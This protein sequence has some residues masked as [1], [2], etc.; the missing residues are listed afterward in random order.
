MKIKSALLLAL[1]A[2]LALGGIHSA[3]ARTWTDAKTGRTLSGDL[4][5]VKEGKVSVKRANG[6]LIQ[7]E[8]EALSKEDQDFVAKQGNAGGGGEGGWPSFRG[9]SRSDRSPDQGLLKK[10]PENGPKLLWQSE[11]CGKGYSG[12]A[13]VDGK[14][15]YT[16]T[17]DGKA[18]IICLNSED[19]KEVWSSD[20]GDDPADGYST[21]WGSGPRGTPTVS[22]GMVYAIS[23]NGSLTAV[24]AAD[25]KRLWSKEF[26]KDY[27]GKVSKWG[28]SES[29][30]AD[31]DKLIVTPG[32]KDGA[33]VALDKKTGK[34]I[35]RSKELTD[36]SEYSSVIIAEGNG[37]KQYVQLFMKTL[38]GVDAETGKL[39]WTSKWPKGRTA[40][41]PTPIYHD[42]K[43]YMTSGYGAGCKLVDISGAEAKDIWQNKEMQNHHGGVVL[44]DGYLYGFSDKGGLLCQ[45]FKTGEKVWVE[46]GQGI[47]KGAV[48]YADGLLYCVDESE[49]S[50]FIAEA[51]SKG[52]S[53]KGRFSLPKET[54]LRE[55]TRG[56]VWTHPVVLDGKLYLRDQDL[57]FCYD[58]K[59]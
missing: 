24:A 36:G 23:A 32:G 31:G 9:A 13:I 54:K 16:G 33:I 22:D 55:G 38:A 4:V 7:L 39:L 19:G 57:V 37:K 52:F 10:W 53:E 56:K 12:P 17:I 51:T 46:R 1:T 20:L 40:V 28:Y 59:G 18:K 49:G 2:I 21:G 5:S 45:D 44:V 35:W 14:V 50:V 30:L 26:V 6:K 25:G 58:V 11:V 27:G 3:L 41:I 29:T 34:T 8:L 42:G 48:H 15:Y 43:V 47:G